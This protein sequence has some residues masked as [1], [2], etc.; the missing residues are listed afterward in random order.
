LIGLITPTPSLDR[1]FPPAAT[2]C[3]QTLADLIA[4]HTQDGPNLIER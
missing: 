3:G 1:G 2:G 4:G